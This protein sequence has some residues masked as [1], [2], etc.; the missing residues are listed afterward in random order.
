MGAGNPHRLPEAC[1]PLHHCASDAILSR[2][3]VLTRVRSGCCHME[4]SVFL[5]ALLQGAAPT[6]TQAE[7]VY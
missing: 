4:R 5:V 1:C 6:E 3:P 7:V 2:I